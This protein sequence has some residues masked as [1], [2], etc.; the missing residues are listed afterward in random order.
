MECSQSQVCTSV[1]QC[2]LLAPNS[3]L[4]VR[5]QLPTDQRNTNYQI[6]VQIKRSAACWE[7][8]KSVSQIKN[9]TSQQLAKVVSQL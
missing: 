3:T 9:P 6:I 5:D 2:L 1:Y 4:I 8:E 7:K